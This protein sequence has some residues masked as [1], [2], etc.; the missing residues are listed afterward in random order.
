MTVWHVCVADLKMIVR[1]RQA[2][3]WALAF[4]LIFVVV[5]GLFRLDQ[6]NPATIAV[7]D[8]SN[9]PVS[10]GLVEGLRS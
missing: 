10:R 6:V 1:N 7:V 9:D 2:L 5:F 8:Q 4:P 3:F